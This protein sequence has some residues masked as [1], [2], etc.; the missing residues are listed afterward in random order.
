MGL[1][2]G[3]GVVE[4]GAALLS[5][6]QPAADHSHPANQF[7][8]H[9]AGAA[10]RHVVLHLGHVVGVQ[11]AGDE[12][13]GVRPVEL[14]VAELVAGRGDPEAPALLVV[15]DGGEDAGRVEARQAQPV[16]GAVHA[17]QRRRT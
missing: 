4:S 16:D 12:D 6:R 3:A 10:D 15:Q 14:L 8:R 11:E 17:H 2:G 9:E 7:I 5:E 1:V 13:S